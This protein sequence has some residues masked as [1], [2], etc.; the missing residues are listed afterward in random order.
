ML[1]NGYF[2]TDYIFEACKNVEKNISD[3][4]FRDPV[5]KSICH[6]LIDGKIAFAR[7][8]TNSSIDLARYSVESIGK[9]V[10]PR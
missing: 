10:F 7:I 3:Q 8:L 5:L 6:G 2:T 9:S 4:I 1:F